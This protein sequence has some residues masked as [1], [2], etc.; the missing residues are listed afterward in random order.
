MWVLKMFDHLCT[1]YKETGKYSLLITLFELF[2]EVTYK[3]TFVSL[4]RKQQNTLPLLNKIV[5]SVW[6]VFL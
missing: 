2:C 5:Q 4:K 6:S 1:L 3:T